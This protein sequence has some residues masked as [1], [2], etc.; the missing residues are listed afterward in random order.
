MCCMLLNT[1]KGPRL[2][3]VLYAAL[4][5]RHF[6]R[7]KGVLVLTAMVNYVRLDKISKV[8]QFVMAYGGLRGAIAFSLVSLTSAELVPPIKTMICACIVAILFTSFIQ[9]SA[10]RGITVNTEFFA[11]L[12]VLNSVPLP[13]LV[14]H[15]FGL[16]SVFT[17]VAFLVSTYHL[18]W[19]NNTRFGFIVG[20]L[21]AWIKAL[22]M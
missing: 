3:S 10:I 6:F 22:D 18:H 7:C 8:D 5:F 4:N 12:L 14:T 15:S 21:T 2:L 20:L 13:S 17:T 9:V 11:W 16:G 19:W 1:W